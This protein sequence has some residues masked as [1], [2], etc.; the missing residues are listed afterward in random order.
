MTIASSDAA[1]QFATLAATSDFHLLRVAFWGG[2]A[3]PMLLPV[4]AL[5]AFDDRPSDSSDYI[6]LSDAH[7]AGSE[8]CKTIRKWS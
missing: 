1:W 4:A 2:C 5:R 3:A 8:P 7:G 6:F